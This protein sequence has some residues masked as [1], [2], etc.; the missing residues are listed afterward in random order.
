MIAKALATPRPKEKKEKLFKKHSKFINVF[1]ISILVVIVVGY[2]VYVNMPIL[3]VRIAGAQAGINAKYPEYHPDGYSIDGPVSY[4]DGEVTINFH[5]NTGNTKFVI[6]QSKSTWDSSAVKNK[7]TADY[8]GEFV[9]TEV[10][11]LTIFTYNGN[12][13]WVNGGILYSISGD[14]KLNNDQIRRIATSS[15]SYTHLTLPTTERV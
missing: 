12:A 11:G 14:A 10:Q 9:A 7:V 6:K 15:V 2:F 5:A 1:S 13:T 8:K 3:S 4:S